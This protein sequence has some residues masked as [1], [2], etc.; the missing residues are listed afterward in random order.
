V[1]T[2]EGPHIGRSDEG[3]QTGDSP[4]DDGED[5]AATGGVKDE[6]ATVADVDVKGEAGKVEEEMDGKGLGVGRG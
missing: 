2:D 4:L 1:E 3:F 6:L 5:R